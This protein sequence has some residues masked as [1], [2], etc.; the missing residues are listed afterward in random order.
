MVQLKVDAVA[1]D[2]KGNP[3]VILREENGRR[4]VHIWIGI[5]EATAISMQLEGQQPPRPLTHDLMAS[6]IGETG[7]KIGRIVITDMQGTTYYAQLHM[8]VGSKGKTID[9]RPSDAIALALRADAPIEIEDELL[10][11]LD[12]IRRE[13]SESTIVDSGETTVH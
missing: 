10:E 2:W 1:V 3:V 13:T 12:D 5:S 7:A 6:I 9:C 4:K 8:Q 11:R